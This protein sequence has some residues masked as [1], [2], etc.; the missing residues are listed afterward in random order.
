MFAR[1]LNACNQI[2]NR[3]IDVSR[4]LREVIGAVNREGEVLFDSC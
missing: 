3:K 4:R 2:W 1:F